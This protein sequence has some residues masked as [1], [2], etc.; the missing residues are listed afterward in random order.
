MGLFSNNNGTFKRGDRVTI[1]YMG[2]SGIIVDIDGTLYSVS[3]INE[4]DRE[5]VEA[6][7]ESDLVKG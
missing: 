5:V 6:F 2:I 7:N 1:R 4:N 3:Y